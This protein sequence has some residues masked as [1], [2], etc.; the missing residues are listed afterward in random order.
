MYDELP[1]MLKAQTTSLGSAAGTLEL[2]LDETL[3]LIYL[4][5][6]RGLLTWDNEWRVYKDSI[7]EYMDVYG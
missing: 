4:G 2:S 7:R 3:M 6:L 1:V 5:Y